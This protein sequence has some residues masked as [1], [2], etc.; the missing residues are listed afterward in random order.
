MNRSDVRGFALPMALAAVALASIAVLAL[1]R[2]ESTRLVD[3][4]RLQAQWRADLAAATAEA[5]VA[6]L[7]ATEPLGARD[8]RVRQGVALGRE[9]DADVTPVVL[10]GRSYAVRLRAA[11]S[12]RVDVLLQDEAGLFNL[13]RTDGEATERL[14]RLLGA[15]A[16]AARRLADALSDFTDEDDLRRADGAER[17]DY[18][19][20]QA[21]APLNDWLVDVRETTGV[22]G[23]S[24]SLDASAMSTLR[25]GAVALAPDAPFNPNT[26]T[27]LA[28][29]AVFGIDEDAAARLIAARE[30]Q[31]LLTA[32][33]VLALLGDAQVDSQLRPSPARSVRLIVHV[34][35]SASE[36]SYVYVSR[37]GVAEEGQDRP[38][39][40]RRADASARAYR[41]ERARADAVGGQAT[42]PDGIH[43]HSP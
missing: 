38:I 17:A 4:R 3:A 7:L 41:R 29:R 13:N 19:I 31:L 30:R 10:D 37:V 27:A 42:L 28:L 9:A 40:V 25:T 5:R 18:L 24:D 39:V 34:A 36:E 6:H 26:G 15:D 23:W 14:L 12:P 43:R 8:I 16:A 35:P 2:V 32:Q 33:D 1:A 20:A 22:L 21:G 11:G